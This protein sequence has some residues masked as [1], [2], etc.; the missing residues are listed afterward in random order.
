MFKLNITQRYIPALMLIAFFV[1]TS[2][3]LCAKM[4]S[5]NDEYAKIF[6]VQEKEYYA[7]CFCINIPLS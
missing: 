4:T 3:Y 2:N 1:I 7:A 5:F 6:K